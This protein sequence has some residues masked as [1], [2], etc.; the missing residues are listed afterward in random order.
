R[1]VPLPGG[2]RLEVQFMEFATGP[3]AL[4]DEKAGT[5]VVDGNGV[6]RIGLQLYRI[7]P[8]LLRHLDQSQ[9][10]RQI[11]VVISGKLGNHVWR[12]AGSNRAA[13]NVE[14]R[15]VLTKRSD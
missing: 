14:A 4:L 2:V 5:V 3:R 1:R 11:S 7:C 6:G 10:A 13:C 15:H 9:P 12:M 8:R